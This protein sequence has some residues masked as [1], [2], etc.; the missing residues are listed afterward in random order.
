MKLQRLRTIAIF[1]HSQMFSVA[2]PTVKS[3]VSPPGTYCFHYHKGKA[4]LT[5]KKK[6]H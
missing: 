4:L 1:T 6:K 2:E 3:N 5:L